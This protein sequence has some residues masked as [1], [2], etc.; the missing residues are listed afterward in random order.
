MSNS[1]FHKWAWS[2]AFEM[3]CQAVDQG[4]STAQVEAK[5]W[6]AFSLTSFS[7]IF[8]PITEVQFT[9][10]YPFCFPFSIT[11]KILLQFLSISSRSKVWSS[12]PQRCALLVITAQHSAFGKAK[13]AEEWAHSQ[14]PGAD[15]WKAQVG[16]K[17][18]RR[19]DVGTLTL[20][21]YALPPSPLF[22]EGKEAGPLSKK[23][24]KRVLDLKTCEKPLYYPRP[25]L[26]FS[27]TW[28]CI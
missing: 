23:A 22:E 1:P 7:L 6:W 12:V 4:R 18:S 27:V 20:V 16:T 14:L 3:L 19:S 24:L 21:R 28:M 11:D 26:R 9:L 8:F 2:P 25:F 10:Y 15:N 17:Q 5:K 13:Y